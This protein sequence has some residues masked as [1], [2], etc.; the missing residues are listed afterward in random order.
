MAHDC[1]NVCLRDRPKFFRAHPRVREPCLAAPPDSPTLSSPRRD[2]TQ[3]GTLSLR[4]P[5][6]TRDSQS[7]T[8]TQ[9]QRHRC[10][11]HGRKRNIH[12]KYSID[13][14]YTHSSHTLPDTQ[15]TSPLDKSKL[16]SQYPAVHFHPRLLLALLLGA[17]GGIL[18]IDRLPTVDLDRALVEKLMALRSAKSA[19]VTRQQHLICENPRRK[20]REGGDHSPVRLPCT[21]PRT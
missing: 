13:R 9:R 12:I 14:L 11:H 20:G 19:P 7:D 2:K 4:Q 3:L 21:A 5:D 16:G 6:L 15:P 10:D 8:G 18:L 1:S 17:S